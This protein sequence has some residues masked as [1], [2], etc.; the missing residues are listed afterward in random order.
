MPFSLHYISKQ[1]FVFTGSGVD[2][3]IHPN[4][5]LGPKTLS[6]TLGSHDGGIS[7]IDEWSVGL[8]M[9]HSPSLKCYKFSFKLTC[10]Q[11]RIREEWDLSF[12]S[13]C[14]FPWKT[15]NSRYWNIFH[16][17]YL[18]FHG[19]NVHSIPPKNIDSLSLFHVMKGKQ[20][21]KNIFQFPHGML[22]F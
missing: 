20:P 2:Y 4:A 9:Q 13:L 12:F 10:L 1:I 19:G 14:F 3:L 7:A 5:P 11:L 22:I 8:K 21:R 6:I 15:L 17:N 16:W 18:G